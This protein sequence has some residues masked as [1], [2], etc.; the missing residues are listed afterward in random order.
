MEIFFSG[1]LGK[2]KLFHCTL[3]LKGLLD[4][5]NKAHRWSY[6]DGLIGIF[7][8]IEVLKKL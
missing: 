4:Y 3:V 5:Q 7:S 8:V 2:F 1:V 6:Y